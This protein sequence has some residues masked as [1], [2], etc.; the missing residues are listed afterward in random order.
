MRNN[1]NE[2]VDGEVLLNDTKVGVLKPTFHG[3]SIAEVLEAQDLC[4]KVRFVLNE[5]KDN[6]C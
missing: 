5:N 6:G 2:H 4:D 1:S 3:I